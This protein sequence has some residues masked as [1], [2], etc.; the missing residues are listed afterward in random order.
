MKRAVL[1]YQAGIANVFEVDTFNMADTDGRT[2]LI[3]ADF[4]T[5]EAFARGLAVAG[6]KVASAACN[7][8]G[9]IAG[10]RWSAMLDDKSIDAAGNTPPFAE[11]M[12]PVWAGVRPDIAFA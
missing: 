11:S 12:R 9:D 4:H 7:Q 2:R 3:Q 10:A 5:C 1:V 6:V 8:A